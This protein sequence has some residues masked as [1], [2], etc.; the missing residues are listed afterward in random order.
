MWETKSKVF[1]SMPVHTNWKIENKVDF[2]FDWLWFGEKTI[3]NPENNSV[4][5]WAVNNV[6][7]WSSSLVWRTLQTKIDIHFLDIG[8]ETYFFMLN[9][10]LVLRQISIKCFQQTKR[11]SRFGSNWRELPE[12]VATA[13]WLFSQCS[14][15]RPGKCSLVEQ[16]GSHEKAVLLSVLLSAFKQNINQRNKPF[17]CRLTAF[18]GKKKNAFPFFQQTLIA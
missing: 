10:M 15:T 6:F 2:E 9:C 8:M 16:G 14:K 12:S 3:K 17:F 5:M 1:W 4:L 18:L 13:C 7:R 11:L